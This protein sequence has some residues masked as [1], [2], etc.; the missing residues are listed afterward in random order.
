MSVRKVFLSSTLKDLE[1]YRDAVVRALAKLDGIVCVQA[2]GARADVPDAV[3]RGR[4][5]ESHLFVGILGHFYGSCPP[6]SE[7]SY[8]ERE[9]DEAVSAKVPRLIFLARENF[10]V[11]ANLIESDD[12]RRKQQRFRAKARA[13]QTSDYFD[14]EQDLARRVVEAIHNH[15][16]GGAGDGSASRARGASSAGSL[17]L[18]GNGGAGGAGGAGGSGR[19]RRFIHT[20]LGAGG[21][22]DADLASAYHFAADPTDPLADASSA[23]VVRMYLWMPD[24]Q[25]FRSSPIQKFTPAAA[26]C[27]PHPKRVVGEIVAGFPP[28]LVAS[29]DLPP[30]R[31]RKDERQRLLAALGATLGECLVAVAT[32]PDS[33][34]GIGR[35]RPNLAHQVIG[36]LFALPLIR[37][38]AGAGARRLDVVLSCNAASVANGSGGSGAS[39]LATLKKVTRACYPKRG[40]STV[41]LLGDTA[42]DR[43]VCAAA[44]LLAW[45][46]ARSDNEGK[47]DYLDLFEHAFAQKDG[48]PSHLEGPSSE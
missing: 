2:Y 12:Q 19:S 6:D 20:R 32:V 24:G 10:G 4:A 26:I 25:Y 45:A 15:F 13:E 40:T 21:L 9:Y 36:D 31:M 7:Q 22:L 3:S 48:S 42:E 14:S 1:T 5:A 41:D 27:A 44:R 18:S 17:A 16:V 47:S 43:A 33:M 35:T 34:L 37:M 30:S 38:H 23:T 8:T 29:L 28:D 11:P 39:P 46:V